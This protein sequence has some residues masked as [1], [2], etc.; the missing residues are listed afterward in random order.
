MRM[1]LV[2]GTRE[3]VKPREKRT[4]LVDAVSGVRPALQ[5][6]A[7]QTIMARLCLDAPGLPQL[8]RLTERYCP[9]QELHLVCPGYCDWI[10]LGTTTVSLSALRRD[11]EAR[12]A[13]A[14][15][16]HRLGAEASLTLGGANV[17]QGKT[18]QA[19]LQ[20]LAD[21]LQV[22]VSALLRIAPISRR[23]SVA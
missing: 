2:G 18:G 14:A 3:V 8:L 20:T 7:P 22:E 16:G 15:I 6:I 9:L 5:D 12:A 17:G 21:L 19:F 13:L 10:V 1:N 23:T 11:P 4:L